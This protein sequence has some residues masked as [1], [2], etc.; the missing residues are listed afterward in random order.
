VLGGTRK[1]YV[2]GRYAN[3]TVSAVEE[4]V[5]ALEGAAGTV[6][7]GSGMAALH[8]ALLLCE[9]TPGAT[10]LAGTDLY[11]A[12]HT[13][14]AALLGPF[15][16]E[17]RFVDMTDLGAVQ[18]ALAG[19][20]GVRAMLF[21]TVSNPLIKVADVEGICT[22]ARAAGALSIVDSTFTP[23]PLVNA[24]NLGADIVVHSATKYFG[25][26]G[27]VTGGLVSVAQQAHEGTLREIVKLTGAVLGPFEAYLIGRGIKTL[28]LRV[29]QQ[30]ENAAA[31]ASWLVEQ[32]V[33]E[34]VNYPGL[35]DHS[36]HEL[37]SK[38]L[39]RPYYGAMLSFEIKGAGRD[40][41]FRFF[42]ALRLVIPAATLGD[43][44]TEVSYPV[45]S[46]HRGWSPAQLRRT[47]ITPGLVRVSAGIEDIE[48]IIADIEQALERAVLVRM[49]DRRPKSRVAGPKSVTAEV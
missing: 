31:L 34:R 26:H 40:E 48:D 42:D 23:P 14:L 15:E 47:G 46:S 1:G 35:P 44:Y 33:I 12:S 29:R 3:P 6:A 10:V 18:Q 17:T 4:A 30:C 9:L 20:K 27:D 25:G 45:I 37:A 7:F 2:Y 41:V 22:A 43:V 38:L 21:E 36:Q 24:L 13:L 28:P 16:V 19:A 49:D 8:A 5:T 11:G 39:R 32:P